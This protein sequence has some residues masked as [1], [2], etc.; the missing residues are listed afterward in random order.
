DALVV[1]PARGPTAGGAA[2]AAA[3]AGRPGPGL[4]AGLL[5]AAN[6]LRELLR[7]ALERFGGRTGPLLH[8]LGDLAGDVLGNLALQLVDPGLQTP[9]ELAAGRR[10]DEQADENADQDP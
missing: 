10:G 5:A 7:S 4:S 8:G 2:G 1:A 6:G 9:T 3:V